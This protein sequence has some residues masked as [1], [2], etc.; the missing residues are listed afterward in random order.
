[1]ISKPAILEREKGSLLISNVSWGVTA[2][3][4]QSSDGGAHTYDWDGPGTQTDQGEGNLTRRTATG[5]VSDSTWDHRNRLERVTVSAGGVVLSRVRYDYD[6]DDRRVSKR[7][8][9]LNN[10]E[11]HRAP[12]TGQSWAR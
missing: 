11:C 8:F 10:V 1:M 6:S 4:R 7:V 2:D 9:G 12:K 3:N 5:E